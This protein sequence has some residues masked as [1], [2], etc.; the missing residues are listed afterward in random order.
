MEEPVPL[1]G[2]EDWE[3]HGPASLNDWRTSPWME[4]IAA[5]AP[6]AT[7][8]GSSP[9]A[10]GTGAAGM[11]GS[12]PPPDRGLSTPGSGSSSRRMSRRGAESTQSGPAGR[13]CGSPDGA[14]TTSSLA[15][16]QVLTRFTDDSYP[17]RIA[18]SL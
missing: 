2:P 8:R 16:T 7:A 5:E 1:A 4:A 9:P 15:W 17:S 6:L 11:T 14:R 18:V 10:P 12:S 13:G 3:S